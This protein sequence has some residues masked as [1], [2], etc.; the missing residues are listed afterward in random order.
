MRVGRR[1]YYDNQTGNTILNTGERVG[2]VL[3]TTIE[4]DIQT[5]RSL[6]ER[7]RETFDVL[8]LDYGQYAKDFAECNGYR[9]NTETKELEFSYRD[10]NEPEIEQPYQAP[11]SE[12][13]EDLKQENMILKAQNKAI[14]ERADFIEEVVAEMAMQVYQ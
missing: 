10:P 4:Q 12:Q 7:N 11:L 8:E 9:V 5:Y 3:P 1:V 6:T 14:S 13:V 2:S